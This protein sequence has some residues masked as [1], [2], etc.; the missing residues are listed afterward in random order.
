MMLTQMLLMLGCHALLLSALEPPPKPV[1]DPRRP[2]PYFSWDTIPLAFH[3][4]NRSGI[5]NESTVHTLA[6]YQLVTIVSRL[7]PYTLAPLRSPSA[8]ARFRKSGT[9]P[10]ALCTHFKLGQTAM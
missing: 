7:P 1:P 10:A 6:K 8:T 5:Y 9:P 3:G 4:A 2:K